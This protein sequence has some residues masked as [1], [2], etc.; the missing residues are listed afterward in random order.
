MSQYMEFDEA[1]RSYSG[2]EGRESDEDY[3][4]LS[5]QKLERDSTIGG[6]AQAKTETSGVSAG[7]RLALAIWSLIAT[8]GAMGILVGI[9]NILPGVGA[10]VGLIA[11]AM[12]C[13]TILGIN[14]VFNRKD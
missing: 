5:G 12:V 9:I 10:V 13:V 14:I 8:I 11:L 2:K 1:S 6:T 3:S 7:Y 4:G